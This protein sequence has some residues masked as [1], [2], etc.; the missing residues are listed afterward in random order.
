MADH[1][2]A[3]GEGR[4]EERKERKET[5]KERKEAKK[6]RKEE[7][8]IARGADAFIRRAT[9]L[10][11]E[12]EAQHRRARLEATTHVGCRQQQ[13]RRTTEN[14]RL[15]EYYGKVTPLFS[16]VAEDAVIL[17]PTQSANRTGSET[18]QKGAYPVEK[19]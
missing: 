11:E 4:R 10:P 14:K 1:D 13:N 12:R 18:R 9:A 19:K 15:T 16:E 8:S 3:D 2:E 6:E 7:Q 17:I 5:K